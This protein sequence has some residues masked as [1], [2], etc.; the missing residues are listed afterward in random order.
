MFQADVQE[1]WLDIDGLHIHCLT[2]GENGSPVILLHGAGIDSA[3]LSWGEAIGPLS[4]RH[5]VFAP[6][7]PGYGLSDKPDI[8]YTTDFYVKTVH[9]LLDVLHLEKVSLVGLSMGGGIA[10]S[11]TLRYPDRVE[12]LV[13]VDSYGIIRADMWP[14]W[15]YL[16]TYFSIHHLP[17]LNELAYRFI[18]ASRDLVRWQM[19]AAGVV[20]STRH[21][22]PH[23]IEQVYQHAHL[24]GRGKAFTSWQ[25][26]ELQWNGLRTDLVERLHEI[27]VPTLI[28][29]G[30]KDP[31]IPLV[32]AQKAHE[33][34]AGSQLYVFKDCG[35]WTP[36]EKPEEFQRI[37]RDFLDP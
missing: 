14:R 31:G 35:H 29:N 7:L 6:D 28:I 33:L 3:A 32:Y 4:A 21:L 16:S 2:A 25:Q 12:K 11:F 13:P 24:P 9:R 19:V 8:Q 1:R 17:F 20:H 27:T 37:V 34:I 36:R 22:S 23:L 18:G 30:D 5:R 10:L 26:S 15:V